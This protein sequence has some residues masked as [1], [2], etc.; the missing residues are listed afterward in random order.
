MVKLE[1]QTVSDV[2][3]GKLRGETEKTK[4][5]REKGKKGL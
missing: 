5:S 2:G 1:K 4:T 3:V